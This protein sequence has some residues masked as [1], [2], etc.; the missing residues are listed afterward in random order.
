[1]TIEKFDG[2]VLLF[3]II[4]RS[5]TTALRLKYIPFYLRYFISFFIR[6][7]RNHP[8]SKLSEK[9]TSNHTNLRMKITHQNDK[10]YYHN[11]RLHT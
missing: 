4:S 9:S 5:M 3:Q 11:I 7:G 6:S 10:N 2:I 1:M 8:F